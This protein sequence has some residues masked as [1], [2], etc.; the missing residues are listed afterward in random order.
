MVLIRCGLVAIA[1]FLGVASYGGPGRAAQR[2][3]YPTVPAR[4]FIKQVSRRLEVQD[5]SRNV[6]TEEWIARQCLLAAASRSTN[7]S[8]GKHTLRANGVVRLTPQLTSF[9]DECLA[10]EGY[11]FR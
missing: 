10:T 11:V 8:L 6:H 7:P 4:E 3:T 1:V 9:F 5:E 2:A